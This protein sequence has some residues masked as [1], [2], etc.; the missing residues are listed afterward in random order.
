MNPKL[1]IVAMTT[2]NS[3]DSTLND[4]A[5]QRLLDELKA[6]NI[7]KRDLSRNILVGETTVGA[8]LSGKQSPTLEN[9]VLILDQLGLHATW[10]LHGQGE[11]YRRKPSSTGLKPIDADQVRARTGVENW[12]L[13]TDVDTTA[14]ERSWLRV[15]AWPDAQK[16]YA[17]NVYM[18]GLAMYRYAKGNA[19]SAKA[20]LRRALSE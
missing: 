14:D 5:R 2:K 10:V 7:T 4:E 12:L 18:I 3:P 13:D 17:S 16:S 15:F 19:D 20:L 11:K 8:I 6:Q 1:A 9:F